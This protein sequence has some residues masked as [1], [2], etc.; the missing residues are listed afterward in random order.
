MK[1]TPV[2]QYGIGQ[3]VRRKEDARF[4][5]GTG[6]YIDDESLP[7][8]THLVILRS[9]HAHARIVA[10]DTAPAMAAPGVLAVLTGADWVADG[11]GGMHKEF[12]KIQ[13]ETHCA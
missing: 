11:L 5:T 9:P 2:E 4:L 6:R 7:D 8:M 10:V 1:D 3:P 12:E 13:S